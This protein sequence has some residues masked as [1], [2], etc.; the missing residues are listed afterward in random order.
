MLLCIRKLA[1]LCLALDLAVTVRGIPSEIHVSDRPGR[2]HDPS[3]I[4]DKAMT[5]LLTTVVEGGILGDSLHDPQS[6]WDIACDIS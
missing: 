5:H 4:R 1:G 6:K 3:D 2:I